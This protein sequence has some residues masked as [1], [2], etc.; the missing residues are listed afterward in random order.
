MTL[1]SILNV[2]TSGFTC[3]SVYI[4]FRTLRIEM[5]R[6]SRDLFLGHSISRACYASNKHFILLPEIIGRNCIKCI[7]THVSMQWHAF[8]C[9]G[10][11]LIS[12]PLSLKRHSSESNR[13][14]SFLVDFY[15][16]S[17]VFLRKS[18]SVLCKSPLIWLK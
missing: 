3:R 15:E 4:H 10:R 14:T 12:D 6:M 2:R 17:N 9:R 16:R 13:P 11:C 18:T 1:F 7:K 8:R 5:R